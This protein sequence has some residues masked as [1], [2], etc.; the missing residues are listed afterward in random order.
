MLEPGARTEL[1]SYSACSN[2]SLRLSHC[3]A[4]PSPQAFPVIK[5]SLCQEMM[6]IQQLNWNGSEQP[7]GSGSAPGLGDSSLTGAWI[8]PLCMAPGHCP[9]L[10]LCQQCS[11]LRCDLGLGLALPAQFR[12][13]SQLRKSHTPGRG[14]SIPWC[15]LP[16][17]IT[18]TLT[19]PSLPQP[20]SSLTGLTAQ[21][22]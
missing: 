16:Q 19:T 10:P 6:K 13:T 17:E 22:I 18:E 7:R 12:V 11:C 15:H 5:L 14:C 20:S 3:M 8:Q 2:V 4:L 1:L 21:T 9:F